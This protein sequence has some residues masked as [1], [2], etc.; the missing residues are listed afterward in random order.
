MAGKFQPTG[1]KFISPPQMSSCKFN[2]TGQVTHLTAGYILDRA[3]GNTGG[4][5]GV[6]GILYAIG[7]PLVSQTSKVKW[8][9]C[10][11]ETNSLS[12]IRSFIRSLPQPFPEAMPWKKSWQYKFFCFLF[13][14]TYSIFKWFKWKHRNKF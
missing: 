9:V 13:R 6:F 2:A 3:E 7:K 11:E 5:G 4:L 8:S 12:F 1:K 14:I 10:N